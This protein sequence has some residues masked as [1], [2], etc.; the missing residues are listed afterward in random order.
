MQKKM[1]NKRI[2]IKPTFSIEMAITVTFFLKNE[3][4]CACVNTNKY[5]VS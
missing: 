1:Q 4:A 2:P 5:I 3:D